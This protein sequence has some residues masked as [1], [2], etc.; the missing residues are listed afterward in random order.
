MHILVINFL[1]I[2]RRCCNERFCNSSRSWG[3]RGHH[4][5]I[6]KKYLETKV[7]STFRNQ[8][9]WPT[10]LLWMSLFLD[11]FYY[12]SMIM[13]CELET[14]GNFQLK[15]KIFWFHYASESPRNFHWPIR[16]NVCWVPMQHN[17]T[18]IIPLSFS[19][20]K[21]VPTRAFR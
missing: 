17:I 14:S 19:K 18:T 15:M 3:I 5:F 7:S 4:C 9:L 13:I 21:S 20:W 6:P 12:A 10:I 16:E 2:E 11:I 8:N 1:L